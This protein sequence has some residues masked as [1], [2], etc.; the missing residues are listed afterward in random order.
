MLDII[1]S[2]SNNLIK[3]I[4]SLKSK[5]NRIN[6][7]MFLIEGIRFVEFAVDNDIELV[8]ICY[9]S[10]LKENNGGLELLDKIFNKKIKAFEIE[11][12]LF[13]SITDTKNTQGILAI[14]KIPDNFELDNFDDISFV[15][16]IDRIQD[17]GNLGTIIRTA[18]SANVD[19]I[20]I[21]K[22]TVDPYNEKVLRSTMGSIFSVSIRYEKN[23]L[24]FISKLQKNKFNVVSS[25]LDTDTYYDK[26]NYKDKVA[27]V[28][29]NEA[30]GIDKEIIEKSNTLVK[31][32]IY[33]KAESLNAS[34][35]AGILMYEIKR[36]MNL[37]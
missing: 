18:D 12:K 20:V 3:L 5:K 32:P 34:V 7:G 14:A 11:R 35:A 16:I 25:Y 24:E 15:L 19:L 8:E 9:S 30:N 28:I 26:I 37:F 36:K 1:K 31:I 2:S 22:G 17:P 4:R 23:I 13:D 27:L 29:G 33:G 6:H 21:N 10:V